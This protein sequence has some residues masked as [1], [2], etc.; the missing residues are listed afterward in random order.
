MERTRSDLS[1][2]LVQRNLQDAI[3]AHQ[4]RLDGA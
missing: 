4:Q 1:L 3:A 2:T